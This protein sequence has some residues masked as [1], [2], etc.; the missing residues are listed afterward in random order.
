M[1]IGPICGKGAIFSVG[2]DAK[3]EA[4]AYQ[5][6]VRLEAIFFGEGVSDDATGGFSFDALLLVG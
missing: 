3:A 1:G 6:H 5:D 2:F 4:L